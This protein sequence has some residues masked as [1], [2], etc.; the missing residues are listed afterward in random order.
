VLA[1]AGSSQQTDAAR[2]QLD[3]VQEVEPKDLLDMIDALASMLSR[4]RA[5]DQQ[6]LAELQVRVGE[7]MRRQHK[8]LPV[9]DR[10]KVDLALAQAYRVAGRRADATTAYKK[11][12]AEFPNDGAIQTAYAQLLLDGQDK[13]SW[14]A[15][16]SKW[17]EI[18]RMSRSGSARWFDAKYAQALV[19]FRLGRPQQSARIVKLT[20]ALHP[21]LGG[22]ATKVRFLEL[23]Q[24]CEA[25]M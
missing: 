1:L 3:G 9:E 8:G 18:E 6:P 12:A 15:A 17:R 2:R 24:R 20:Q 21:D 22:P 7:R 4:A 11:L 19:H 14:Q 16:L 10:R 5:G 23:L 25:A 13:A